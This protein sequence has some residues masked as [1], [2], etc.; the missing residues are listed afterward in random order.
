MSGLLCKHVVHRLASHAKS[1]QQ[2]GV[3]LLTSTL[4]FCC[5]EM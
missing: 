5:Q 3:H 1:K 2:A 4:V